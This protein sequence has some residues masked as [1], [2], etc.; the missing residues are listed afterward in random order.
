MLP[1]AQS[2]MHSLLCREMSPYSLGE[3]ERLFKDRTIGT[4]GLSINSVIRNAFLIP[5]NIQ[6]KIN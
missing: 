1:L 6:A 5:C 3:L 2:K 4:D